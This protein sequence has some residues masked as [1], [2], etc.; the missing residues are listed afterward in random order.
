MSMKEITLIRVCLLGSVA[1]I[2]ALYLISFTMVAEEVGSGEITQDH[3]G[4]RVKL[5]GFVEGLREHSSGH[6]FFE[7]R[8]DTGVVDVVVWEDKAEQLMLSGTELERLQD[9][10]GIEITGRVERYRGSLQVVL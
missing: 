1:G 4:M 2:I 10:A 6:I 7:L 5:S 9:G 3:I 8:D